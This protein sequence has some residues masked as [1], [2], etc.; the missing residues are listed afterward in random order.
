MRNFRPPSQVT[1]LLLM[2]VLCSLRFTAYAQSATA[3]LSGTIVDQNGAIVPGANVTVSN[4]AT[5][6]QRQVITS[7]AG[8]FTMPLLPPS[9]Y[10]VRVERQGFAPL[11]VKDVVLN[12]GDQK[13]LQIQLKAG[14]VNATVTVDSNAETVRTDGSVGTVVDRQ[15]VAN[16]PLNGRS[17]QAL[18]QLTPGV[19]LAPTGGGGTSPTGNGQ[20]SVNGQRLTSNYFTVDGV[21][22]NTGVNART[23]FSAGE[24]G[25]GATIAVS[26]L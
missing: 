23:G 21:S 1:F 10:T 5:G 13:T 18:I 8:Y 6:L 2:L 12:V 20:F 7:D 4:A 3:N 16:M 22:A 24:A 26:C 14:D 9:T 19:V 25:S 15:F 17:L 11:E